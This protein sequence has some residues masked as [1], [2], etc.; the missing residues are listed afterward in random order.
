MAFAEAL[1]GSAARPAACRVVWE[2]PRQAVMPMSQPRRRWMDLRVG[3]RAEQV[4][5]FEVRARTVASSATCAQIADVRAGFV[6]MTNDGTAGGGRTNYGG[7]TA[8]IA[9]NKE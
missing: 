6:G 5:G 3:G 7:V 1:R 4:A 2:P 9:T 8:K